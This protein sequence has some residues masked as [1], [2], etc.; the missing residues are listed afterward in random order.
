MDDEAFLEDDEGNWSDTGGTSLATPIWAAAAA[1]WNHEDEE[2]GRPGI[3]FLDP[4]LYS[5]GNDPVTY[6]RDFHD[7]TEGSNGFSATKGWDE[8]T[9]WGTPLQS[10]LANNHAT[11]TYAG[12]H[13][14]FQGETAWLAAVLTDEGSSQPL[15]GRAVRF[16]VGPDS[17]EATTSASGVALCSLQFTG[18]PGSYTLNASVAATAA[19][20]GASASS[21]FEAFAGE[22]ERTPPGEHDGKMI[23]HSFLSDIQLNGEAGTPLETPLFTVRPGKDL[24]V[25]ANWSDENG[26]CP[27][28]LDFVAVA[29]AGQPAAGCIE[30]FGRDGEH[31]EGEAELGPAP[32]KPGTYDIV[33]NFEEVYSC[34]EYWSAS[35]SSSYPVLAKVKVPLAPHWYGDGTRLKEG[36]A[37]K[38]AT[39]GSLTLNLNGS[40]SLTCDAKDRESVENPAGG[41]PG[42]DRV[43]ELSLSDCKEASK[44]TVCAK[45][46]KPKVAAGGLPWSSE[47]VGGSPIRDELSDVELTITCAK[48]GASKQIERPE[49]F[50]DAGNGLYRRPRIRRRGLRRAR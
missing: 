5:L 50:S 4:L 25:K 49:G 39:K 46:E 48:A 47:L 45:G 19:Y 35:G 21:P 32:R 6:A 29:F 10:E 33:A 8:A 41:E 24:T 44:G 1:V 20:Y 43:T 23:G 2:S 22:N 7:I 3:G 28:C 36:V 37:Q 16:T 26:G 13:G 18:S 31:G 11:L 12:A 27:E 15:P 40:P 34:G 14:A 17:C 38:V 30:S 9:G 42:T